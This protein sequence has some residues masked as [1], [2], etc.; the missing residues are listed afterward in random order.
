MRRFGG[1][2]MDCFDWTYVFI[3][4]FRH[5]VIISYFLLGVTL[6]RCGD[7][8]GVELICAVE[9]S[10][11]SGSWSR[12]ELGANCEARSYCVLRCTRYVYIY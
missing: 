8:L 6:S 3:N 10:S 9:R 1:F 2:E 12:A 11:G 4:Y 5:G 7:C